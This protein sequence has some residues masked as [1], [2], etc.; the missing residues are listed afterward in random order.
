MTK[1]ERIGAIISGKEVDRIPISF[2]WHYPEVDE[3]PKLLAEAIIRD[4][5][6]FDLDFIKMMPS[7]MY[8]VE[9]W[10][11]VVGD[12][13][14][15]MGFKKLLTGPIS[16][17]TDWLKIAKKNPTQGARGR[18]LLCLQEVRRTIGPEPPILQTVFSPLTSAA[19]IAGKALLWT[20]MRENPSLLKTALENITATEEEFIA[21][22][23]A[24][25]A[26]G[27][28]LA[29]QFAGDDLL[30]KEE[31]EEWCA[32]YEHRLLKIIQKHS[33]FSIM[34]LHGQRIFF[35][36]F[37]NYQIEAM[38]WEDESLSMKAGK[39]LFPGTVI[40]GLPRSSWICSAS[41]KEIQFRTKQI[42]EEMGH[43]RFILA[44]GC[45]MSLQIPRENLR[46]IRAVVEER[47]L[48]GSGHKF[49]G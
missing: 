25:G 44:P 40:G 12:A 47:R 16:Q 14:P 18:E 17:A 33:S 42:L 36:R 31:H 11:C 5:Q 6:E 29:T 15:E 45:V 19:K 26:S 7:G 30:T 21:A 2:W 22:C 24:H 39:E 41:P 9:D 49:A 27:I 32:P 28:F 38:N 34:H 3:N 13:D 1:R 48:H 23:F 20:H 4:H 43:E 35:D 46:M 37:L 8:G 10:G